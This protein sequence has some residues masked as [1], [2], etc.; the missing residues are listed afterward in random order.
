M[1]KRSAETG[2]QTLVD[3]LSSIDLANLLLDQLIT[4]L[5][6]LD[7]F[8]A[9]DDQLGDLGENLL[10]DLGSCLV[11]G[12]GIWVSQRVICIRIVSNLR[13]L[14]CRAVM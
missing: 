11:L 10:G 6:D 4:L 5:A 7:N 3:L 8:G 13:P 9:R 14:T 1:T 12:K 2:Q